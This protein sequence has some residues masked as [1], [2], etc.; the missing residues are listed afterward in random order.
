MSGILFF[1]FASCHP[2]TDPSNTLLRWRPQSNKVKLGCPSNQGFTSM[3]LL[4]AYKY[5]TK[6]ILQCKIH[7]LIEKNPFDLFC[8]DVTVAASVQGKLSSDWCT[9]TDILIA[10]KCF[11]IFCLHYLRWKTLTPV[12]SATNS[13]SPFSFKARPFG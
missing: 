9:S 12:S 7:V 13:S 10:M 3:H 11:L 4:C 6:D 5:D 1:I 2:L 8:S